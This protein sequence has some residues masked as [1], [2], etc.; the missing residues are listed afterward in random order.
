MD[1]KITTSTQ[2]RNRNRQPNKQ[3]TT[4]TQKRNRQPTTQEMVTEIDNWQT[5]NNHKNI[6]ETA[7]ETENRKTMGINK[8]LRPPTTQETVTKIENWQTKDICGKKATGYVHETATKTENQK[9]MGIN[10]FGG[11]P[12]HRKRR[13]K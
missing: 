2:K 7:M 13:Q 6:H 8:S 12:Q 5:N 10:K 3:E 9:T 1:R 11:H 4:S